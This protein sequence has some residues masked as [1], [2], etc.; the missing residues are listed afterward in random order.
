MTNWNA[1]Q[2]YNA[3]PCLPPSQDVETKAILKQ[4]VK[5]RAALAELKQAAELIPNQSML[6]NTLPIMEAQASSEIENIVTTT[7]KLFQFMDS[8]SQADP[9]TKE[10][11]RYRTALFKGF[12]SLDKRPLCTQTAILVCSEIKGADMDI[13]KVTGTALKSTQDGHTIYTPPE[14]ESII[15]DKLSDW[16]KFINENEEL[17]PLIIMAIAHYQF[18]AIH[19][20]SDGNG[21]TGRILN[22]LMLIDKGLLTLPILYL[23]RYIIQTKNDYY[24]GLLNVTQNQAWEEWILY[25]LKGIEETANWTRLKIETI[26]AL[27]EHTVQYIKQTSPKIYTYELV[28]LLFK[29]PY[30]RIVYLE[31]LEIVSRQTASKYLKE[32]VNIGVLR[33]VQQGRDK[34][35]LHPKLVDILIN[36]TNEFI[37]YPIEA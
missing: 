30:T 3:L 9:V 12:K 25:I 28:N 32:L 17:D 22:S 14:G 36:D 34:L 13:R 23:S 18:E 20:F 21:R 7:D 8:E 19:P 16:E 27:Q 29:Q 33:E 2:P 10:A 37:P 4:V 24:S 15:R 6:I 5:S 26:R 31:K 1:N 35:F 11:L